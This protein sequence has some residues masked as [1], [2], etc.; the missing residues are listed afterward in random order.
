VVPCWS[1]NPSDHPRRCSSFS[2]EYA[3][4]VAGDQCAFSKH[5]LCNTWPWQGNK[6]VYQASPVVAS[7]ALKTKGGHIPKAGP[8]ARAAKTEADAIRAA[9]EENTVR[10][11]KATRRATRV[12]SYTYKEAEQAEKRKFNAV[13][14]E[15][16]LRYQMRAPVGLSLRA[17]WMDLRLPQ[18]ST[19]GWWHLYDDDKE[20]W[21]FIIEIAKEETYA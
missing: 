6:G 4:D 17:Q 8:K 5:V 16:A 9:V 21:P 11:R 3:C 20:L 13:Q 1:Q 12:H 14:R 2:R 18:W 19:W 15:L 7:L 10:G